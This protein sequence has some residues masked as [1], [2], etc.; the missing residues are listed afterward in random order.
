MT[1]RVAGV[2][3]QRVMVAAV[4]AKRIM[5]GVGGSAVQAWSSF[6]AAGMGIDKASPNQSTS[7]SV[8]NEITGWQARAGFPGSAYT[9]RGLVL[10][11]GVTVNLVS[12]CAR[13]A[14][15]AHAS[16][17][18]RL[19]ANGVVIVNGTSGANV[20]QADLAGYT[21]TA[22]TLLTIESFT[23]NGSFD[24]AVVIAGTTTYISAVPA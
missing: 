13:A 20:T 2:A 24:R 16:M 7:V 6:P 18:H 15:S 10:P 21:T 1:V 3:I 4:A 23:S 19:L 8:W 12:R 11:A 9:S 22:E 5:V 17:T 14:T